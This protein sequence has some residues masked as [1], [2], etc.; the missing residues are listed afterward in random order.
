M[1][2][3]L[4]GHLCTNWCKVM[5]KEHMD[6]TKAFYHAWVPSSTHVVMFGCQLTKLQK[7]CR[8]INVIVSNEAKM[9]YFIGQMY[10]SDYFTEEQMTKYKM[11]LDTNKAWDPTLNH[12]SKL[13]AQ[14]K[15][16]GNN[17]VAN[18]RF[19]SAATMFDVPSDRTIAMTKSSGDFTSRDLYIKS[20]EESLALAPDYMTNA[21]TRAP[22]PTPVINPM[23][24]LRLKMEAQCKQFDL[25]LKQNSDLVASFAKASATTN[26]SSGTTLKLRHTGCKRLWAQ[27]KECPNCNKMCTHK[28]ANCFS[29]AANADKCPTNW[30]VPS[31]I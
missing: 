1:I 17:R 5:T 18:S 2:K 29:L 20:L 6:A 28:P 13:F 22:A 8:T 14:H 26:P 31:S 24:T 27:L 25:L 4:L 16:Y 3:S 11:R 19:K 15:A 30:N 9:L 21:P 10:K 7:K 23:A 12:F